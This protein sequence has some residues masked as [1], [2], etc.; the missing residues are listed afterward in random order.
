MKGKIV[1]VLIEKLV[2]EDTLS[3]GPEYYLQPLDEYKNRWDEILV[4]KKTNMWQK[5]PALH[6][7]LNKKVEILGEVTETIDTITIDYIE[8]KEVE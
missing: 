5:D 1:G 2:G 3:A 8:V 7:F 4:R 6:K